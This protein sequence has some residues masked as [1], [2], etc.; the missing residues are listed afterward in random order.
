MR[1]KFI[2]IAVLLIVNAV[3]TVCCCG[4]SGMLDLTGIH[5]AGEESTGEVVE[6]KLAGKINHFGVTDFHAVVTDVKVWLRE[7]PVSK[8]LNAASDKTGWWEMKVLKQKG[9]DIEVSFVYEKDGWV[10]TKSNVI[11]I[12]DDDNTDLAIQFID[13]EYFF[14]DMKPGT[15][16]LLAAL[17]PPGAGSKMENAMVATVGKSWASM[18]DDRLPHGDPGAVVNAV[19]GAVGPVYFNRNVRPD[20]SQKDVSVDGGVAWMNVPPGT[21]I[22]SA[23]K[24]GFEYPDVKFVIEKSDAAAGIMLYIAS[25]PDSINGTNDSAKGEY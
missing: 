17:L 18:H 24:E 21:H 10:T 2:I 8:S 20:L 25:P 4:Q 14:G 11:T 22:V 15:E 9:M 5:P 3:S 19:P 12:T 7:Y 23:D 6:V 1:K 16:K 13:P